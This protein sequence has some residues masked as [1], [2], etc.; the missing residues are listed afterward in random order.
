MGTT[1]VFV[2]C[3]N[4]NTRIPVTDFIHDGEQWSEIGRDSSM[5]I[6]TGD[7]SGLGIVVIGP[8]NRRTDVYRLYDLRCRN[9][10]RSVVVKDAKLFGYL[11]TRR[12]N[13]DSVSLTEIAASI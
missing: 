3:D 12:A 4:H 5:T 8:T 9:C 10:D 6:A 2:Y 11:D 7:Q 1:K 13:D